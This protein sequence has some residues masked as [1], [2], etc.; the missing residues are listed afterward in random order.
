[1]GFLIAIGLTASLNGCEALFHQ[2]AAYGN[3]SEQKTLRLVAVKG[4]LTYQQLHQLKSG[5]EY[6]ILQ[7]FALDMGY[8]LKIKLV[9]NKK[10]LVQEI[11]AGRADVGAARLTDFLIRDSELP[12]SPVYDEEKQSLVCRKGVK[13]SF[14]SRGELDSRNKWKLAI[15]YP[16]TEKELIQNFRDSAPKLKITTFYKSSS[17]TILKRITK[18]KIECTLM[19]RLEAQY[20]LKAFPK[21]KIVKDIS[22]AYPY[23]FLIAKKRTDLSLQLRYWMTKAARHQ[24]LSKTKSRVK[25]KPSALSNGDV[26]RFAKDRK[27][28]LP[29][30]SHLFKKH[31]QNFGVP[32]QLAAAVAYQESKWNPDAESF[33]GVKGF[34]QLT[35]ET[36]IHLGVEDR[37]DPNQ[38][39]W[40]GIKYIKML[41]DRQP[42]GLPFNERLALALATYNVGPAHMLD[43]QKLARRLGKNPYSWKDL[44]E[45]LPLLAD[46]AYLPYLKYGPARGNEPVEYVHRVFGYLDLITVQI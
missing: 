30:Y 28:V 11:Q 13:V 1:M 35:Q 25:D 16:R 6:E 8:R 20:F 36:A 29:Q 26:R 22:P 45:V 37:L 17:L 4:P 23:F 32:W 40:G 14:D 15:N 5:F 44:K 41:I 12:R 3:S 21:L 42:K 27:K 9:K 34:M 46:K 18:G 43:A 19:D 2:K 39:I 24:V 7:H 33:T 38:S 10:Q 31:S